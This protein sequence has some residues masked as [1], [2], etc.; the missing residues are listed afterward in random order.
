PSTLLT[1]HYLIADPAYI[2]YLH[3]SLHDALPIYLRILGHYQFA[4]VFG[5]Q[6]GSDDES[7]AYHQKLMTL[8]TWQS[9]VVITSFVQFFETVR[10]EEH[11]SE[12]QSRFYLVCRLLLEKIKHV[13]INH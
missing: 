4:D 12:L 5:I 8:D 11:T 1:S 13:F 9:D 10:S 2:L 7:S 6:K 3:F